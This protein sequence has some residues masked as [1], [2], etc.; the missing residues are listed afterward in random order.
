MEEKYFHVIIKPYYHYRS[1]ESI[2]NED[3]RP[4]TKIMAAND[5][6]I[7]AV[8]WI[9]RI[10]VHLNKFCLSRSP[11]GISL[12]PGCLMGSDFPLQ[13]TYK[14]RPWFIE[15]WNTKIVSDLREVLSSV[16]AKLL[17]NNEQM[18][19]L[20]DE[21]ED[22]VKFV[23]R[24]WPWSEDAEKFG[25]PQA[26]IPVFHRGNKC[27]SRLS[28]RSNG[29]THSSANTA[30]P[31]TN[32]QNGQ[33]GNISALDINDAPATSSI[34]KNTDKVFEDDPLVNKTFFIL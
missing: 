2:E 21:M 13:S 14:L 22:P 7:V 8:N 32:I 10:F 17:T 28:L 27:A 5:S 33:G 12:S 20:D 9:S 31:M 29:I 3:I 34:D 16:N 6:M 18:G 26:L 11:R 23:I 24:T 1:A 19:T 15:I 30:N 4:D 25:L